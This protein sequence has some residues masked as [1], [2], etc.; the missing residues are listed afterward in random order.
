MH[1]TAPDAPVDVMITTT[2]ISIVNCAADILWSRA[3][4]RYPIKFALSE[5]GIGWVPYFLE[6]ADYVYEH[7]HAWT[8]QSF[9]GRLPSEVFREHVLTC[10]IDD[11]AGVKNRHDVGIETIT[12]ECD[13]PHSD[14]T[15]PRAPER[16][17]EYLEDVPDDEVNQI[18]HQNA[19]REFR[20]DSFEHRPRQRC[21]VG[22]LRSE[23]G[24]VDLEQKSIRRGKPPTLEPGK[25][26][27]TADIVKQLASAFAPS[28]E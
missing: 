22:A 11:A 2:P 25:P 12:W 19:M 7:H 17:A 10:F 1:F 27:T 8:H 18:T 26:V 16:L 9:G 23:A 5:G 3:I 21:T 24:D 6:R 4:K 28:G 14:T 13:Y 15:W 20:L